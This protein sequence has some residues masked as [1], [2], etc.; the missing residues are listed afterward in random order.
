MRIDNTYRSAALAARSAAA[1]KRADGVGFDPV[2]GEE[3]PGA[4]TALGG[5]DAAGSIDALL[6]LQAVDDPVLKKR[7]AVR[8][9]RTLLDGLDAMKAELLA[10]GISEGRLNRMM[11]VLGQARERT[12]DG[13]DSILDEIEL[14]V[15]VELA[16]LGRY[17]TLASR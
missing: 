11:A 16:K 3:A 4:A 13:L 12:G 15:A 6:A 7:K 14:R 17:P 8:R 1:R 10:G 9:G 2:G 5:L